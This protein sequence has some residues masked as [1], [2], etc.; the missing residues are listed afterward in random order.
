MPNKPSSYYPEISDLVTA[1]DKIKDIVKDVVDGIV[2][3]SKAGGKGAEPRVLFPEGIDL[4]DVTVALG[5][6][7]KGLEIAIKI[8]GPKSGSAKKLA[9]NDGGDPAGEAKQG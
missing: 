5:L 2:V 7:A 6:T 8:A 1:G 4:I 9:P 3:K